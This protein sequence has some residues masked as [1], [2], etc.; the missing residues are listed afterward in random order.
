[1]KVLLIDSYDSFVYII[2]DYFGYLGCDVKILRSDNLSNVDFLGYDVLVLG[3]GPGHPEDSVYLD[4]IR[5]FSG[6][7]PIFG[8]CLG[9]QAICMVYGASVVKAESRLHGKTSL[10]R[11]NNS[12]CLRGLAN[13]LRVTRYHSLV[14][15]ESEIDSMQLGVDAHSLDDGYVMAI[16]HRYHLV[17]AVQFHPESIMTQDGIKIF[18]N[19][20]SS[21]KS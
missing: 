4:L 17:Q 3:P 6:V 12:S 11:H 18:S 8:V 20:L 14:A 15:V 5:N 10:V 1:M 13:P 19:F 2:R 9:L 7:R 21:V 16:S